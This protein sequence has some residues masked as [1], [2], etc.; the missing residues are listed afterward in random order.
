M[1]SN[2][3]LTKDEKHC[4]GKNL[5]F[6]Y[7]IWLSRKT[8]FHAYVWRECWWGKMFLRQVLQH[9]LQDFGRSIG[10]PWSPAPMCTH[11]NV[12][13]LLNF[14]FAPV[15]TSAT[16]V[17]LSGASM[18]PCSLSHL[19]F[20]A[21]DH[22]PAMPIINVPLSWAITNRN[23]N[24]IFSCLQCENNEILLLIVLSFIQLDPPFLCSKKMPLLN[25][26]ISLRHLLHLG[27]HPFSAPFPNSICVSLSA[28][29]PNDLQLP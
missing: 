18:S 4:L 27:I 23:K 11:P 17:F 9:F 26:R 1:F 20:A 21:L 10:K 29:E 5:R 12:S 7:S 3:I 15:S 2:F 13:V 28:F 14:T 22:T 6:T 24:A 25:L 8:Q 16:S 19:L